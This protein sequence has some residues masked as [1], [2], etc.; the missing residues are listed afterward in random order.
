MTHNTHRDGLMTIG[1]LSVRTGVPVRTIRFYCDEGVLEARRS[2]AGHRLFDPATAVDRLQLVRRLRTLGLGLPA[3]MGVLT[4]TTSTTDAV[5]IE[6]ASLDTELAALTWRRAALAAVADAPPGRHAARL[7]LLAAVGDG[8][9]AY[10]DLIAFWRRLLTPIAPELFDAFAAMNI[11]APPADPTSRQVVAYA[12]LATAATDPVLTAALTK[13]LWRHDPGHVRDKRALLAGVAEACAIVD[14]L[15]A[16]HV[17]PR[18][19]AELDRF[20][21]AH[22]AARGVR[23]T[24]EFRR[25]LLYGADDYDPRIRRYWTLTTEITGTTTTGAAQDWLYRALSRS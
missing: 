19:G 12:E 16:A 10:D 6:K 9:R 2:A 13:Q 3:I 14:P 15:V 21:A 17:E 4:G 25:R 5:A 24:A 1:E 8:R 20:L 22:A 11:P 7:E 23:P 18:P